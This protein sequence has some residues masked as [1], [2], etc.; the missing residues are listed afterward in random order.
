M[1][2]PELYAIV[3]AKRPE[4]AVAQLLLRKPGFSTSNVL[5]RHDGRWIEDYM[6]SAMILSH[7]LGMLPIGCRLSR[8]RCG[9]VVISETVQDAPRCMGEGATPLEAI[10]TYLLESKHD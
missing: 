1:N 3:V 10:A 6:A 8:A 5:M 2:L 7:W 4:A 9:F